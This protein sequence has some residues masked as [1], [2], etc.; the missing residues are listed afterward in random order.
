MNI[1]E[2][3]SYDKLQDLQELIEIEMD[4][5]KPFCYICEECGYI[6]KDPHDVSDHLKNV[7][8]YPDEDAAISTKFVYK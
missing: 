7:H 8:G 3:M 2:F 6:D 5:R 1:L 4:R